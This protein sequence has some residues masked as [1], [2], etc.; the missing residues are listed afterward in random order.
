MRN[1]QLR[2]NSRSFSNCLPLPSSWANQTKDFGGA[3]NVRP[4]C[5]AQSWCIGCKSTF[6]LINS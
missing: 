4:F 5:N 1:L 3:H 6:P 2:V